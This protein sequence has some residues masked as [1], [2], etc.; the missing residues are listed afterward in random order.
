V[1][2]GHFSELLS[3]LVGEVPCARGGEC[4]RSM[5]MDLCMYVGITPRKVSI[6]EAREWQTALLPV[7]ACGGLSTD[8]KLSWKLLSRLMSSSWA[9]RICILR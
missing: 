5:E 8:E 9:S 4:G 1:C 6:R 2:F 3:A 7:G